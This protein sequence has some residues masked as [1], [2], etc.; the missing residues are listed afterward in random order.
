MGYAAPQS[1]I[2]TGQQGTQLSSSKNTLI[3]WIIISNTWTTYG[4]QLIYYTERSRPR[5]IVLMM[6]QLTGHLYPVYMMRWSKH[7]AKMKQ[8]YSM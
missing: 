3:T 1:N 6:G 7:E 5:R 4:N 8:A 2:T